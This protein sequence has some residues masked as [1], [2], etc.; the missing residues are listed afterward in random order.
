MYVHLPL[1]ITLCRTQ[2]PQKFA[3]KCTYYAT[4]CLPRYILTR[5]E[6]LTQHTALYKIHPNMNNADQLAMALG[7]AKGLSRRRSL[8]DK[9]QPD[10]AASMSSS[11]PEICS[12]C[13]AEAAAV[14]ISKT[15]S[16]TKQPMC[17]IHYYTTRSCRIDPQRVSIIDNGEVTKQLPYAQELFSE[18]FLELQNEI[19]TECARSFN[20]MAKLGSDPLSIL[21]DNRRK[22]SAVAK[23][24]RINKKGS[25]QQGGEYDG[26]FMTHIQQREVDLMEEQRKRSK[27]DRRLRD[28]RLQS[29][30]NI[31]PYK[32]RKIST[33]SSW[34]LVL[35]GDTQTSR[36]SSDSLRHLQG[37]VADFKMKCTCGGDGLRVGSTMSKNDDVAKAE[38]WGTKRDDN[39]SERYQCQKCGKIWNQ[40]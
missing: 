31:N 12:F 30:N 33:K 8:H 5:L 29:E 39:V 23:P 24:P 9:I 11:E 37:E 4:N 20:E 16:K 21:N 40:E 7:K 17:L 35:N 14:S 26:G 38:T 6:S 1:L 18:A 34:H 32:R 2:D 22:S 28:T 15:I 36:F 25:K 27:D 10:S 19:A 3:P 13:G